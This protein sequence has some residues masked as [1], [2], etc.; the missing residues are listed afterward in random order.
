MCVCW[1]YTMATCGAKSVP[2]TDK[3]SITIN[4]VN[5]LYG[6]YKSCK[7]VKQRLVYHAAFSFFK[8]FLLVMMKSIGPMKKL[9]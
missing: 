4:F 5:T 3:R 1:K 7:V 6:D 9:H 8:A 2:L